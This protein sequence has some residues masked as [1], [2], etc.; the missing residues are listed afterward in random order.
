MRAR[1]GPIQD[2]GDGVAAKKGDAAI[3]PERNAQVS[4]RCGAKWVDQPDIDRDRRG[5]EDTATM[6]PRR[7]DLKQFAVVASLARNAELAAA[8]EARHDWHDC[9][10][11]LALAVLQRRL[12]ACLLAELD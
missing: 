11:G 10:D 3:S 7:D 6:L 9:D 4:L 8:I 2:I 5:V 1:A 12:H